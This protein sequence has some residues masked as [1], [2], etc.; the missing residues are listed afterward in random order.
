LEWS[1][2]DE[3]YAE[4][5]ELYGALTDSSEDIWATLLKMLGIYDSP[6]TYD[7][8]G[9]QFVVVPKYSKDAVAFLNTQLFTT[10]IWL[11]NQDVLSK[12]TPIMVLRLSKDAGCDINQFVSW[13]PNGPSFRNLYCK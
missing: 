8:T 12:L 11:L 6:K 9:N 3:S 2:E 4:L 13:R 1:K 7:M 10:P 5:D